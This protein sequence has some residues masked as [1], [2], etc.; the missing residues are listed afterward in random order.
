MPWRVGTMSQLRWDF[1]HEVVELGSSVTQACH[2]FGISRKTGY[3][4][5]VRHRAN[6]SDELIDRSRRPSRSPSKSSSDLEAEVLAIRDQFGWGA[7]KIAALL[8]NRDEAAGVQRWL[9]SERT[10]GNILRR[11]GRIARPEPVAFEAPQFFERSA[12][13][14]LWQCDF[15]GP[16]EVQRQRVHP[17]TILDDHSRYLLALTVCADLQMKT[18]WEVLWTTFGEYGLPRQLL[19]D[20]AFA[21]S[22][23]G[24]PTLS[25]IEGRLVRLGVGPIHGRAYHPQTQGKIERLHGTLEREVWPYLDRG[26]AQVFAAGV[27]RWRREVYNVLRPHEALDGRAPLARFSPSPRPRPERLPEVVYPAKSELRKVANGGDISWGGYRIL[28]GAGLC[29]EVVR[30]EERERELAVFYAWKQIRLVPHEQ[31][32]RD[33]LL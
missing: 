26:D 31:L 15:K 4:W 5:L 27:E 29:G 17:F 28:V 24:I 2:K 10:I 3:K 12:P 8:R 6:R 9:P 21:G 11:H 19:C 20:G 25:W 7:P 23:G 13:H 18:A 14:E 32:K 22:H 16:L 33:R 1:V 30:V